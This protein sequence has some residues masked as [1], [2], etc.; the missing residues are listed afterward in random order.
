MLTGVCMMDNIV[1]FRLVNR[2]FS[3]IFAEDYPFGYPEAEALVIATIHGG[4]IVECLVIMREREWG[5]SSIT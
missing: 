2:R 5:E 1:G 3:Q 4:K